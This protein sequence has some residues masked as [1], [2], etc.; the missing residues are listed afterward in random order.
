MSPTTP[1]KIGLE[2]DI[3]PIGQSPRCC[4]VGEI[5]LQMVHGS[6][7]DSWCEVGRSIDIES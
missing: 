5:C 4:H 2:D 6:T 7:N 3:V 1:D